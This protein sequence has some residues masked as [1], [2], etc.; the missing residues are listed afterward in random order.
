MSLKEIPSNNNSPEAMPQPSIIAI[1]KTLSKLNLD[2]IVP[3]FNKFFY[4]VT[5]HW[6]PLF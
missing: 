5:L 2:S 3:F 4:H 1:S 6:Y